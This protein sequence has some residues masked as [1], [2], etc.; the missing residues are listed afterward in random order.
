MTAFK[1][2]LA[3]QLQDPEIR[4]EYEVVMQ[5]VQEKLAVAQAQHQA[6]RGRP[7]AEIL[8]ESEQKYGV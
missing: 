3:E 5:D 7:L 8:M 6:G 2:F 1:D 4:A